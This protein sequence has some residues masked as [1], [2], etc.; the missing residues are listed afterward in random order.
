M[1]GKEYQ[2]IRGEGENEKKKSKQF[3]QDLFTVCV[4]I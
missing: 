3:G 1:E 2:Y 4:M